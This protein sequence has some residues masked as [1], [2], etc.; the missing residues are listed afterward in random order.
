MCG[1]YDYL[2]SVECVNVCKLT[3][4]DR[5][6]RYDCSVLS[7][8]WKAPRVLTGFLASTAHASQCASSSCGGNRRRN[9]FKSVCLFLNCIPI[10][11]WIMINL[12][13]SLNC[14]TY[15]TIWAYFLVI[16]F[17]SLEKNGN[18]VLNLV[19]EKEKNRFIICLFGCWEIR[20]NDNRDLS[21]C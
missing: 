14:L 8:A 2:V 20:R 12:I 6:G 1:C 13:C 17:V 7:C 3:K 10:V 5:T 19:I 9:R 21:I 18:Y 16:S 15:P 11:A 4:G